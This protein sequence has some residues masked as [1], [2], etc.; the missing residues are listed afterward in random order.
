L[1]EEGVE[2]EV[3]SMIK[4]EVEEG[5]EGNLVLLQQGN[6]EGEEGGIET[7]VIDN[8]RAIYLRNEEEEDAAVDNLVR[9]SA[10]GAEYE[11]SNNDGEVEEEGTTESTTGIIR[12]NRVERHGGRRAHR[13][14]KR[15]RKA[16]FVYE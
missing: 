16:G 1:G 9:E 7:L 10:V 13:A 8:D 4:E 2:V 5:E 6:M 15:A 11:I 12:H 3:I 14:H